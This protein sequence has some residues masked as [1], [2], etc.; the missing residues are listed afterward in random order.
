MRKIQFT[1]LIL[2]NTDTSMICRKV[3]LKTNVIGVMHLFIL[4]FGVILARVDIASE[5]IA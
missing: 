1:K 3:V 5:L 4:P 2:A